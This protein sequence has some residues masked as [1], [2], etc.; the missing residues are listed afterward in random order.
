MKI[1]HDGKLGER[2][3]P[4]WQLWLLGPVTFPMISPDSLAALITQV[5]GAAALI[6]GIWAF[7]QYLRYERVKKEQEVRELREVAG[8]ATIA[9]AFDLKM[10]MLES[11]TTT[12]C[13]LYHVVYEL[14]LTNTGRLPIRVESCRLTPYL[15]VEQDLP[16]DPAVAHVNLPTGDEASQGHVTWTAGETVPVTVGPGT[17]RPVAPAE[18]TSLKQGFSVRAR[19]KQYFALTCEVK[20]EHEAAPRTFLQWR[21]LSDATR[22]LEG[23]DF[24]K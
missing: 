3:Q 22:A 21:D 11:P 5:S 19:R 2:G 18:F 12:E 8:K 13:G 6:G 14:K 17:N 9:S 1:K 15:G 16:N 7:G 24:L 4:S 20:L 10:K 23:D